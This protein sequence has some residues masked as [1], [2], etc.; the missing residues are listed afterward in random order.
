MGL[1]SVLRA[2]LVVTGTIFLSACG[3][4]TLT[5]RNIDPSGN[6]SRADY[7]A[8]R[9]RG[10]K[11]AAHQDETNPDV[12]GQQD[13]DEAPPIPPMP[14]ELM[15]PPV[16][17][18]T[19]S[20]KRVSVT[21]T[22]NVPLRDVLIEL[23]REAG[24]NLELDPRISGGV[25]FSAHNQP[26]GEVLKRICNLAGL[27][28]I[29]EG[30][31]VRVELDEPY[32]QS[33]QLDYLSLARR[34][35]S[36]TSI[37]TNVFDTNVANAGASGSGSGNGSSGSDNNS[38]SRVSSTSAADFWSEVEKSMTQIMAAS[39]RRGGDKEKSAGSFSID[40]QSGMITVFGDSRQ[41]TAV[42]SY[43]TK[44]KRKAYAQ[45]LIDAR[46][47]EVELDDEFKSGIDW[48][49][50]FN[51]AFNAAANFGPA[52]VGAPF[53]SATTA[54]NGVF[55]ASLNTKEFSGILNFV[56][57]FGTTRVLS[58]PRV[59]VLNN[60]TAVMKVATN[61]V[62]FVT[63]AQF[64]TVTNA[65]GS[66]V[67]TTPVYTS[68]PHTVPVGL[69]MTVQPAID[70]EHERVTM[71]L[72]PTISRIVGEAADPSIGLNA[73]AAGVSS[74]VVSNIPV[75]AVREMDSVIQLRSGE[76]AVMGGLMQDS[77]I[78]QDNGIPPLD[79]VPVA[80]ALFKSRDN[81]GSTTELVI[82][83]RATIADQ[84]GPDVAD[85]DLYERYNND[86]RPLPISAKRHAAIPNADPT[87]LPPPP[88]PAELTPLSEEPQ[89]DD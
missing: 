8:L 88:L 81:E 63:Q 25:I 67:T 52:A 79:D 26:F 22:E 49:T 33:Y 75:L 37:A 13:S 87:L 20:E 55:T 34:A 72:R 61:Q 10:D 83:L 39:A 78:N 15:P 76:V 59:T 47:I 42:D 43:L 62:Y 32:Q 53:T 38:T 71:T 57:G 70:A 23:G 41:Q 28:A 64:T 19:G 7:L 36:E 82:L 2:G 40:Q 68:T 44:L 50:L 31:F 27:R 54:T 9:H 29:S 21:V 66:A 56:R 65:N 6:L 51:G 86:P 69:V 73:A 4:S 58:S 35:S 77:S 60:Q 1:R 24:I 12:Q 17:P 85:R 3:D 11:A 30:D 46:I 5:T 14:V 89:H 74:P 18:P 45:V 84:P 48:R 16:A 80:G